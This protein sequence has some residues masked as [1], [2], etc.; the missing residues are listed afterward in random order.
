MSEFSR[1]IPAIFYDIFNPLNVLELT[2]QPPPKFIS[3]YLLELEDI[4]TN[5]SPAERDSFLGSKTK[6]KVEKLI[7]SQSPLKTKKKI[8]STSKN[9]VLKK[10]KKA[11]LTLKLN[12]DD[13]ETLRAI[14]A[15]LQM[16]KKNVFSE[17][18]SDPKC[19][20]NL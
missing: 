11:K 17:P 16:S 14:V 20:K 8:K 5:T 7:N 3:M 13:A 12:N 4:F 10:N 2:L 1:F 19:F 18:F 15:Y 6:K 9:V